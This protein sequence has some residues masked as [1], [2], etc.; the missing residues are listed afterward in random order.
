MTTSPGFEAPPPGMF[1][2]AGTTPITF[3]GAFI[4]AS[5][6]RAPKTLAAPAMSYFIS[7]ISAAGLREMPP[8]S[9]V[10]PLP[11][12]TTGFFDFGPPL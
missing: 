12:S 4:A 3:T 7:S 11:M 9:N 5:A 2:T 8:V 1:S 10:T 6:S